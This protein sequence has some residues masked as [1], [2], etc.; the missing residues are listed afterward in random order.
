M[1]W[2]WQNALGVVPIV[3]IAA[4]ITR[5]FPM[6][7]ATRHAIWTGALIAFL[8]PPVFSNSSLPT[9]QTLEQ[10]ATNQNQA[11]TYLLGEPELTTQPD[12]HRPAQTEPLTP[13]YT[14]PRP[15]IEHIVGNPARTRY[16]RNSN[17]SSALPLPAI[18]ELSDGLAR[19]AENTHASRTRRSQRAA[20]GSNTDPISATPVDPSPRIAPDP[21]ESSIAPATT[22]TPPPVVIDTSVWTRWKLYLL[23]IREALVNMPPFPL[24]LWLTGASLVMLIGT[25]RVIRF[26]WM[27]RSIE[28]APAHIQSHVDT[29]AAQLDLP[30]APKTVI[31]SQRVTPM[32]YCGMRPILVLP[33]E[34]WSQLDAPGRAAV[35]Q[36]ELAHLRRRDH[37]ICWIESLVAVVYWWHPIAWWVRSRVRDEADLSCDA[38]VTALLP[39]YRK[40]YAEALVSTRKYISLPGRTP[41]SVGLGATRVR[42][43]RFSRRLLMIMTTR[44][45]P[46]LTLPGVALSLA[47]LVGTSVT[48]PMWACPPDETEAEHQKDHAHEHQD[49]QDTRST[50][51]AFMN[52]SGE[53][54]LSY[55]AQAALEQALNA[56]HELDIELDVELDDL[57]GVLAQLQRSFEKL[58][59]K[60]AKLGSDAH[61]YIDQEAM[62]QLSH[63]LGRLY[64]TMAPKPVNHEPPRA[65]A[66]PSAP[67][68]P[69]APTHA[70]GVGAGDCS[71]IVQIPYELFGDSD[72]TDALITIFVRPDVPTLVSPGEN[73]IVIHGNSATQDAFATFLAGISSNEE[74]Q[75][76]YP[77]P[78]GKLEDVWNLMRLSDVPIFVSRGEGAIIVRGNALQQ[79]AFADFMTI[80]HP[81]GTAQ[82]APQ[83]DEAEARAFFEAQL[84]NEARQ[85]QT[86]RHQRE[87][88]AHQRAAQAEQ[89]KVEA[90]QRAAQ[91]EQRK[92]EAKARTRAEARIR[93]ESNECEDNDQARA[94]EDQG[95]DFRRQADRMRAAAERVMQRANQ[96]R[97]RQQQRIESHANQLR[98]R[99][100][101]HAQK[102]QQRHEQHVQKMQSKAEAYYAKAEEYHTQAEQMR[103]EAEQLADELES[104]SEEFDDLD[105]DDRDEVAYRMDKIRATIE[106]HTSRASA[107]DEKA[108]AKRAAAEELFESLEGAEDELEAASEQIEDELEQA[109]DELEAAADQIE[110]ELEQ[111]EE[112]AEA[113]MEQAA[114]LEEQADESDDND[115]DEDDEDDDPIA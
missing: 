46:G 6:R 44:S 57:D 87:A 47:L 84:S 67:M 36:H 30:R 24:A 60:S 109:L 7:A 42:A 88:E 38:W 111:A 9:L 32:I 107:Y 98:Q 77:L 22:T 43:K 51:E 56:L 23:A 85:R 101:E 63:A 74:Y 75:Q 94:M 93:A 58:A 62:G 78:E 89:R 1:S 54:S 49:T 91:A 100:E 52:E 40:N 33:T 114:E 106:K 104:L 25:W 112:E 95:E 37:W 16:T 90:H 68:A 80:V 13:T 26:K 4:L 102:L 2:L 8:I 70:T 17:A 71:A 92:A 20:S 14:L 41:P 76:A 73:S 96:T 18:A 3:I 19:P 35:I 97:D 28:P 103:E 53:E 86:E 5:V 65:D 45:R 105:A 64:S 11:G 72:K 27:L 113:L 55:E 61:K 82:T 12:A 29:L 110:A 15:V 21:L 99:A 34:L 81:D 66:P 115:N 10:L 108:S 48:S 83:A 69:Q 50:F 31:C 79:K 59:K 39:Q